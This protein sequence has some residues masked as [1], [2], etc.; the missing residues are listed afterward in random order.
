[1][2][3]PAASSSWTDLLGPC[4]TGRVAAELLGITQAELSRR[5]RRGRVL[6]VPTQSR[7]WVYPAG[8]F[9]THGRRAAATVPK[10]ESVLAWLL[11]AGNGVGAARWMATPNT[12]LSG[13]T[14]WE[15]L[16]AHPVRVV[17]AAERQASAWTGGR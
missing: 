12:F 16:R 8:Q 11:G 10:L 9:E 1:M 7:R 3:S 17:A 5:R 14:P 15:A 4:L 6:G 2:A 13:H